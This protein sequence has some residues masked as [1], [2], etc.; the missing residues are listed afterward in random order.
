MKHNHPNDDDS[1]D[2]STSSNSDVK[3]TVP[4][5]RPRQ[6][7]VDDEDNLPQHELTAIRS[8]KNASYGPIDQSDDN[9]DTDY[10]DRDS[11]THDHHP[12]GS[13]NKQV[14]MD[15][16]VERLGMGRFQYLILFAAGLC[17]AADSME[18]LLLSFLSVVLRAVWDLSDTQTAALTSAVFVGALAGTLVLGRLGDTLGRKPVFTLTAGIICLSGFLTAVANNYTTLLAF[19]T[20]VGFGVGGLTV[21]FDTLAE[22]VP[23]SHR[24]QNL[25]LIEYFWTAGTLRK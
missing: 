3:N 5:R 18:V 10:E 22:F 13:Y 7:V 8:T 2:G 24:G 19:R 21:P 23:H 14:T 12:D 25:L 20:A 11:N 6:V 1:D 15:Q 17:F 9:E 16:A 4:N